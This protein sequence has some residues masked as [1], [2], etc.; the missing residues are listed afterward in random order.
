MVTAIVEC[1]TQVPHTLPPPP[2]SHCSPASHLLNSFVGWWWERK[3]FEMF[4]SS[5]SPKR[6]GFYLNLLKEEIRYFSFVS[7]L[8][9][10]SQRLHQ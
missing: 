2:P 10:H 8:K 7:P 1:A 4:F 6:S 9:L 5:D 3:L